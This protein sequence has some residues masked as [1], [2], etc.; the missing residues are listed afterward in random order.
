MD[1]SHQKIVT[2][3]FRSVFSVSESIEEGQLIGELVGNLF[4][5]LDNQAV[6][7]FGAYEKTSLRGAIFFTQLRFSTPIK[8][9]MLAPVAVSTEHQGKGI[10]QELIT[11]GLNTMQQRTVDVITTYGDPA[12]YSKVGFEPLSET[13]IEAPLTLSM[14]V[15]WQGQSLTQ[16][17]IPTIAEKPA[18]V[19][20]FNNAV[21]W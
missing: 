5:T 11:H 12:F 8:V 18:C 3:L 10:G 1:T 19:A 4:T 14:P 6:I 17:P 21:Y 9:Y 2:E 15:G 13:T 7:G 20:A 16:T